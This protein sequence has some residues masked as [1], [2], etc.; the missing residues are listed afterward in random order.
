MQTEKLKNIANVSLGYSFRGSVKNKKGGNMLVVQAKNAKDSLYIDSED[1]LIKV[2]HPVYEDR[3]VLLNDIILTSRGY[4]HASV[5]KIDS[6]MIASSSV[7][8]L[9][10]KN[11]N[12]LLPEYL[13][14]YLNSPQGQASINRNQT[15][16]M[17]KVMLKPDLENIEI[18]IPNIEKQKT[19]IQLFK[20]I[21]SMQNILLKKQTLLNQTFNGLLSQITH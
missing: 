9:R 13:A 3:L 5:S 20:T 14:L 15:G 18:P 6:N 11:T 8:I 12:I 16:S 17:I 4:F 19:V 21:N 10:S 1:E 7:Y 2:D